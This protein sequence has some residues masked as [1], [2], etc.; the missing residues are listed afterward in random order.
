MR[1]LALVL[2]LLGIVL[3]GV[4]L[5]P[6]PA[7][8]VD[9]GDGELTQCWCVYRGA[10]LWCYRCCDLVNGCYDLYCASTCP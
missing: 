9:G 8:T 3:T 2:T 7:G 4:L 10:G 5:G 6:G 1:K